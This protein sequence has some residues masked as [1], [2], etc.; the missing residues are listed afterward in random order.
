[1]T[2]ELSVPAA[3]ERYLRAVNTG[4]VDGFPTSFAD[5][6]LVLDVNREI[7]GM[8]A[9]KEWARSDIFAVDV[10]LRVEEV[11]E[12]GGRILVRVRIDGTFDRT[13]LPNPLLMNHVFTIVDGKITEL[14]IALA[15]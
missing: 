6:A 13:G 1:M 12:N 3:I 7:R 5:N 14:R 15:S 9:I 4:D 8:E 10:R 11:T 2:T